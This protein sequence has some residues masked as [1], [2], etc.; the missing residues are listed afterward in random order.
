MTSEIK[1][2]RT[3]DQKAA[4]AMCDLILS[5]AAEMMAG[6]VGAPVELIMDRLVTYVAA[7][8]VSTFGRDQAINMLRF[9]AGRIEAGAFDNL[10]PNNTVN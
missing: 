3:T 10:I 4:R 8:T 5:R 1:I 9:A 6:E 2:E 7:Q